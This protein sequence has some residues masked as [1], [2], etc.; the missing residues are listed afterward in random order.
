MSKIFLI[1]FVES[2]VQAFNELKENLI[3]HAELVQLDYSKNFV[4]RDIQMDHQ[5][6]SF[7]VSD[8]NPKVEMRIC[9]PKMI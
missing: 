1:Q 5:S 2:A 7:T 6:L 3:A 4:G 8:K 9:T